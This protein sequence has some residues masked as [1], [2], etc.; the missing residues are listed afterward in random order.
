MQAFVDRFR[1]KASK[2]RQAQ[3]RL[4]ALAKLQP[5][6]EITQESAIPFRFP[7]PERPLSP[8]IVRM[9]GVSVGYEPGKPVLT[10]STCA[11]TTTTASRCS[12][13]NGNGKST[14]AKLLA[15]A[16]AAGGR[17]RSR[18]RRS[19]RSASSRSTSSTS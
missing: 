14:F 13:R 17:H 9:E 16:A 19:S 8:P 15:G 11:S 7:E 1:A 2:A 5:I 4:K 12:A 18:A 10:G 3:S 6:A